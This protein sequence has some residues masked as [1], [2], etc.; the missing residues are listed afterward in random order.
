MSPEAREPELVEFPWHVPVSALAW[1][2]VHEVAEKGGR[3]ERRRCLLVGPGLVQ[4]YLPLKAEPGL[5]R[6]FVETKPTEDGILSFAGRYGLLG[7]DVRRMV[8]LP[9]PDP[10]TSTLG[11]GEPI[12]SWQA[13]IVAMQEAVWLWDAVRN[14]DLDRLALVVHWTAD[15]QL[16]D[17]RNSYEQISSFMPEEARESRSYH[18]IASRD[19]DS[20][21]FSQFTPGEYLGPAQRVIQRLVNDKLA[22][23]ISSRLLWDASQ[24]RLGLFLTPNGLIG[25]LWLQFAE[26][27][28]SRLDFRACIQCAKWLYVHP[29][30][31]RTNK[32]YCS[33]PCKSKSYRERRKIEA[34]A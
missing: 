21:M 27:I 16:V 24:G 7:G 33:D 10:S 14:V 11:L 12:E 2:D 31:H 19:I 15:M 26:S 32:R 28:S 25:A 5:F 22:S 29:D 3:G 1:A 13:E 18:L 17:Y 23:R 8:L 34:R 9:T 20:E 4:A 30:S 6:S